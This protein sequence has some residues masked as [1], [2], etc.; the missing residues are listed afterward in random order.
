M[1]IV[2]IGD[3]RH[4]VELHAV[5]EARDGY[6]QPVETFAKHSDAWASIEPIS[7]SEKIKS[8]QIKGER[9]HKITIRYNSAVV[10]TDR[11]I[12]GT[13]TFEIVGIVNPEE[14][15]ALMQLDCKELV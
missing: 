5:T 11:V 12:Y 8:E 4:R 7:M 2:R 10:R 13:R 14:R 6:G 9:T 3:M 1:G 15:N